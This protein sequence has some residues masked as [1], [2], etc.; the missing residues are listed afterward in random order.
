MQSSLESKGL[1]CR[2]DKA[3]QQRRLDVHGTSAHM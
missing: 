2:L 1:L 3:R